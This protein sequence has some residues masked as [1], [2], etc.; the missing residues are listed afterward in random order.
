MASPTTSFPEQQGAGM[1]PPGPPATLT[2]GLMMAALN[3]KAPGN[4][5]A[6]LLYYYQHMAEKCWG[7]NSPPGSDASS[8]TSNPRTTSADILSGKTYNLITFFIYC[9][10]V[11]LSTTCIRISSNSRCLPTLAGK[12]K[13]EL[14]RWSFAKG[15]FHLP[16][17]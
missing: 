9:K 2:P 15:C 16:Q 17:E 4:D 1:P 5:P 7:L 8:T 3:S 11:L 13:I 6:A 12:L 14:R 10:E